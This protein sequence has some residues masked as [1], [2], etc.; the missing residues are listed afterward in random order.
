MEPAATALMVLLSC[1]PDAADCREMR[2][3]ETY[4][5]MEACRET[6]P[7]VLERLNNADR[8]VIGR[9]ALA[10]DGAP[11]VDRMVTASIPAADSDVATGGEVATVYVT[12]Y[13]EGRPVTQAYGVQRSP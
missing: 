8:T 3:T 12:R 10:A 13:V 5:S 4:S 6:L 7:S 1:S 11:P 9:C 2:G